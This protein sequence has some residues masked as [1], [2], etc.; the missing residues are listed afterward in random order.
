MGNW[1]WVVEVA[2]QQFGLI[3]MDQLVEQGWSK[4]ALR[5]LVERERLVRVRRGLYRLP[6]TNRGWRHR[7]YEA[8]ILAGPGAALSH[9]SAAHLW[10][11]D[12][13]EREPAVVD[14]CV[15][16]RSR[17]RVDDVRIHL[18][19]RRFS[20]L[21]CG[22]FWVTSVAQTLLDLAATLD[23]ESLEVALDSAQRRYRQ[24]DAWL[25]ALASARDPRTT[26][27]LTRLQT[28][29]QARGGQRTDSSLEVRAWRVLR[30]ARLPV[31]PRLQHEVFDASGYVMRVD[32]AWPAER[33]AVHV[34]GFQWHG[35]RQ[36]FDRDADQRNRLSAAGWDSLVVTNATLHGHWPETLRAKLKERNPQRRLPW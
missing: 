1:G 5:W 15:P 16:G 25:A 32:F 23:E 19:R 29:A 8:L 24:V 12:G 21:R 30:R 6:G 14:L 10:R 13:F 11:L 2:Q 36:A 33:I 27:G 35:S 31:A 28:L 18:P 9:S 34:D 22:A 26:P 7:A 17:P 4:E 3:T 20:T